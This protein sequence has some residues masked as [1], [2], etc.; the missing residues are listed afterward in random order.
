VISIT[1]TGEGIPTEELPNIF[2]RFYRVDKSHTRGNG[3]YGLRLAIAKRLV[4]AHSGII[5]VRSK[6]GQG[7]RFTFTVPAS[8]S[9]EEHYV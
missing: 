2:E 9:K 8:G 7:S 5:E 1:D 4:E 6:L 3:G